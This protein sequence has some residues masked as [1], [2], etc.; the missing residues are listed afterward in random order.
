VEDLDGDDLRL[1]IE[2][3]DKVLIKEDDDLMYVDSE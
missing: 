1:D 2:G 3:W